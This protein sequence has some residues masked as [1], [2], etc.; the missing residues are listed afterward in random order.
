MQ[1]A[2]VQGN[3]SQGSGL[4]PALPWS[5]HFLESFVAPWSQGSKGFEE[6]GLLPGV[7]QLWDGG[8]LNTA[9][10]GGQPP[11]PWDGCQPLTPPHREA[12]LCS[13]KGA[14]EAHPD[15]GSLAQASFPLTP[16]GLCPFAC[17]PWPAG[18]GRAR[19]PCLHP[20]SQLPVLWGWASCPKEKGD[21]LRLLWVTPA[22]EPG[23]MG[24]L[25]NSSGP[26]FPHL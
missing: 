15:W 4:C 21:C 24:K 14:R 5:L 25:L 17:H 1:P 9:R 12:G 6:A 10:F 20:T 16:A 22:G 3:S 8:D 2:A 19:P 18:A 13:H 11:A 23:A 7:T 26:P